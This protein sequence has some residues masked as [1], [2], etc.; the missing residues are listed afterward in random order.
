[1]IIGLNYHRP[2][3][4]E[5]EAWLHELRTMVASSLVS[6]KGYESE[7]K[8]I[9]DAMKMEKAKAAW[10]RGAAHDLRSPLTLIN[11]PIEDLLDTKLSNS[12][13]SQL[14]LAKRNV[15]RLMRLVNALM[16]FFAIGGRQ[17]SR[18]LRPHGSGSLR[19]RPRRIVF[20]L[21]WND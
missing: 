3:D 4:A 10:F 21:L 5:Y 9:E 19:G 2:F 11:G 14:Q 18:S 15:D 16:D 17:S 7:Q 6:V 13:R 8:R 1:M 12:Q 20:D